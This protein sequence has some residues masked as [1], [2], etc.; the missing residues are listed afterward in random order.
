MDFIPPSSSFSSSSSSSSPWKY[1]I[2]LSFRG[3]DTCK[4][5]TNHLYFGLKQ[6][7]IFNF[8]DDEKL[9][10][11]TFIAPTLLKAIEELWFVV[12]ILSRDYAS[13]RWCLIELTKIIECME[14]T[15]FL[16]V[17]H[18]VDPS[19]VRNHRRTFA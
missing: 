1:D 8:R 12:I 18:Y 5:F 7:G 10:Q 3:E 2:F 13:S 19:D 15:R 4:N 14:K 16:P 9:K 11:G 6:K 17:F